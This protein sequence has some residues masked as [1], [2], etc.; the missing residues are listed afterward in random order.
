MKLARCILPILAVGLLLAACAPT[1]NAPLPTLA[2]L[3]PSRTPTP[4]PTI[5]LTASPTR[6]LTPTPTA[7]PTH[8]VT[9]SPTVTPSRTPT[10]TPSRT[11]TFTITPSE[12]KTQTPSRTPTA[13]LTPTEAVPSISRFEAN[14]DSV[15]RGGQVTLVWEIDADSILVELQNKNQETLDAFTLQPP[16][17]TRPVTLPAVIGDLAIFSLTARRG[18]EVVSIDLGVEVECEFP[19]FFDADRELA[20]SRA[21]C[22]LGVPITNNGAYQAFETGYMIYTP[23]FNRV[24]VLYAGVNGGSYVT[25]FPKRTNAPL[26]NSPPGNLFEPEAEFRGVWLD[27]DA[28]TTRD[29]EDE[30]GFG[31]TPEIQT[32]L[33]TQQERGTGALYI[34]TGTGFVFRLVTNPQQPDTGIWQ[35]LR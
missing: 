18:E 4:S 28:P 32:P 26:P 1:P 6:T 15:V 16:A 5:T 19:W 12:T 13:T 34:G 24:Y 14:P 17:G 8:T 22:P 27:T 30:I 33:Q 21:A 23:N 3:P 11:P 29:W 9:P 10:V 7:T 35:K 31:L 2:V 20:N 25:Q